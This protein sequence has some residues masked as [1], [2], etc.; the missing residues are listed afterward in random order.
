MHVKMI[1]A[2]KCILENELRMS[3]KFRNF[4]SDND[5]KLEK[6]KTKTNAFKP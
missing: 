5:E 6:Q 2:L 3:L 1:P 4:T